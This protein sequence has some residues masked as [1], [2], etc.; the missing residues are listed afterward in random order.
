MVWRDLYG[1]VPY[2][3]LLKLKVQENESEFVEVT[4]KRIVATF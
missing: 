3:V 2:N 1:R 4:G